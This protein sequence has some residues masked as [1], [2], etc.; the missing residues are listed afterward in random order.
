MRA[1]HAP[2]AMPA[3]APFDRPPDEDVLAGAEVLVPWRAPGLVAVPA[4]VVI[5]GVAVEVLALEN[6][7]GA[8]IVVD[9]VC[10]ASANSSSFV[11]QEAALWDDPSRAPHC[12]SSSMHFSTYIQVAFRCRVSAQMDMD[13]QAGSC[14]V[15]SV[16]APRKSA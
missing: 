4:P 10:M 2:T 9:L 5:V 11:L 7:V 14:H 13:W 15:G 1:A 3:M 6:V 16:Q 12:H 8:T